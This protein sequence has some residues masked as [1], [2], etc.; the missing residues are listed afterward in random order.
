MIPLR[1]VQNS[2]LQHVCA[3]PS[4][5]KAVFLLEGGTIKRGVYLSV[6]TCMTVDER[7]SLPRGALIAC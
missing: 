2:S 4:V 6:R 1:A 3:L 7:P 5:C